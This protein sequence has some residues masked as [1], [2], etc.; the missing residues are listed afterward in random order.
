MTALSF[1]PG[2]SRVSSP[3]CG[4]TLPGAPTYD[5]GP[6]AAFLGVPEG[7]GWRLARTG[8]ASEI[9]L[10]LDPHQPLVLAAYADG[11]PV[12]RGG[13]EDAGLPPPAITP[14]FWRALDPQEQSPSR[15]E[16][17][18]GR[19]RTSAIRL[20]LLTDPNAC[21]IAGDELIL[22]ESEPAPGGRLWP[23]TGSGT[24]ILN[25]QRLPVVTG[26]DSEAQA[27]RLHLLGRHL[28]GWRCEDGQI[29][30][31]SGQRGLGCGGRR[32]AQAPHHG[33][34]LAGYPASAGRAARSV[35]A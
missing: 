26:A 15:L 2:S 31:L 22:G 17:L 21:P 25:G 34:G 20:W 3:R 27:H 5:D 4:S 18:T 24:I 32:S 30:F 13:G 10:R 35:A 8:A 16:P 23:V 9:A 12:R 28:P 19:A 7:G 14:S 29:Q 1:P 11:R 33:R 6:P